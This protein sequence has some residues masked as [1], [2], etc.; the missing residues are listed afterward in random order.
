MS[1]LILK[2]RVR[3][4][5]TRNK[6]N[7][8]DNEQEMIAI[9]RMKTRK[10]TKKNLCPTEISKT[11]KS[12]SSPHVRWKHW[13]YWQRQLTSVELQFEFAML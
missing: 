11:K 4:T 5:K 3:V 1:L 9:T 2:R 13:M 8:V 10:R 7:E 6:T 12:D